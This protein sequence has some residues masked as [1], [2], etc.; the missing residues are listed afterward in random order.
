[1]HRTAPRGIGTEQTVWSG[2]RGC[3]ELALCLP[4]VLP[5]CQSKPLLSRTLRSATWQS[6]QST[7]KHRQ[8]E[9]RSLGRG[10]GFFSLDGLGR[11]P[12]LVTLAIPASA[13]TI[14]VTE[15]KTVNVAAS[16]VT[17][18]RPY[19]PPT[20]PTTAQ[21]RSS[22]PT[23]SGR[24]STMARRRPAQRMDW[25][26]GERRAVVELRRQDKPPPVPLECECELGDGRVD[27]RGQ[28]AG[29]GALG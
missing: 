24:A 3:C 26:S 29:C 19:T 18:T 12:C 14:S 9:P 22:T 21:R 17:T 8:R 4:R 11:C 10:Q 27:H 13:N 1:M 6:S 23:W 5:P 20:R 28:I 15:P 2:V 16:T 7:N 25:H